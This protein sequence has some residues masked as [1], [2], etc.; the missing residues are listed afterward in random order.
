MLGS[1][2]PGW[3]FGLERAGRWLVPEADA[4]L[5]AIA[6]VLMLRGFD[7]LRF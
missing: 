5:K 4:I 6:G 1:S 7:Y 2:D 3:M